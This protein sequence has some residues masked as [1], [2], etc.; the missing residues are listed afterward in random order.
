M[1]AGALA[2]ALI[3]A[4]RT[5]TRAMAPAPVPRGSPVDGL[6]DE[7][8]EVERPEAVAS[9]LAEFLDDSG[10]LSRV[11]VWLAGPDGLTAIG[12][13][14]PTW[15]TPPEVRAYLVRLDRAFPVA[16]LATE[17]LGALRPA[18]EAWVR[19]TAADVVVPLCDRD[20]LIGVCVGDRPYRRALRDGER[21]RV[22]EAA[23][24]AARALTLLS[25]RREIEARTALT[26]EVEL[27]EAVRTA[28]SAGDHREVAGVA[29]AVS[30]QQAARVAG[31]LWYAAALPD[32]RL[33]VLIGDVAGRGTPA[34]LVSAA[35]VGAAQSAI[36]L[37]AAECAPGAVLAQ[38][39]DVVVGIDAGRHRVTVLGAIVDRRPGAAP[40]IDVAIA[41]H[42][43]GYLVRRS[44]GAVELVPLI[45]QG[46]PLGEPAWKASAMSRPLAPGDV[47]VLTSDGVTQARDRAGQVWGERRL[48][49]TLREHGP[50]AG[51]GLAD[52]VLAAV[53]G[54][55]G[56]TGH[57]DDLLVI[58]LAV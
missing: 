17:R 37:A 6:V 34:A 33:F 42:R 41:G 27:A 4:G 26:R 31:D 28:R 51:A 49:R 38:L 24:V 25:L 53:T 56:S 45:G 52:A 48:Q 46:A 20:A 2:A 44:E 39:H 1:A 30:Y 57:D 22:D 40:R 10:L 7:L 50:E 54:H 18:L 13:K 5:V 21:L 12:G 58:A 15:P 36:G 55:S 43:G 19:A 14:G 47:V 9:A 35:V 23:R 32:G 16:D 29:I 3:A 11:Q 8:A